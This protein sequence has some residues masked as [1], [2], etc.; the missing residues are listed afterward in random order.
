MPMS[1][2]TQITAP[3]KESFGDIL[4]RWE[5]SG[6]SRQSEARIREKEYKP[7]DHSTSYK[8]LPIDG[9]LDLHGFTAAEARTQLEYFIAKARNAGWRKVLI[10]HGKGLH[11]KEEPVLKKTVMDFIAEC[12]WTGAHGI[13]K[14]DKGGSGTVWVAIKK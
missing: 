6:G 5:K 11:S 1:K 9:M 13:P 12:P 2:K 7:E 14:A 3:K 4:A 10:I 8:K